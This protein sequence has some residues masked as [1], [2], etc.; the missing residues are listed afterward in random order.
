MIDK[1]INCAHETAKDTLEDLAS[2]EDLQRIEKMFDLLLGDMQDV[3]EH[4]RRLEDVPDLAR[5]TLYSA[6]RNEEHCF[7]A[8]T[9]LNQ[10]A[11]LLSTMRADQ[12]RQSAGM[13]D[14]RN[15]LVRLDGTILDFIAEQRQH[16][17]APGD[18]SNGLNRSSK[19]FWPAGAATTSA[20]KRSSFT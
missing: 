19:P 17:V 5:K 13:E 3:V 4:L 14:L 1:L 11:E 9:A 15:L 6:L 2:R 8:A 7:A 16:N 18:S 10:Q 12:A 20:P